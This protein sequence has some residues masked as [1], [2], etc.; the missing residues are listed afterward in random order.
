M[1]EDV[2]VLWVFK[3]PSSGPSHLHPFPSFKVLDLTGNLIISHPICLSEFVSS[4][5]YHLL[6]F[7]PK[8]ISAINSIKNHNY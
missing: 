1:Y 6:Y 5:L 2:I 8:Q 3:E 7:F 4:L